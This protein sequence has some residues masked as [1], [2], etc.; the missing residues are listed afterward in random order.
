MSELRAVKITLTKKKS[1]PRSWSLNWLAALCL[2]AAVPCRA[3][4][5]LVPVDLQCKLFVKIF[6]FEPKL[7][8]KL[9]S[10]LVVGI[11]YQEKFRASLL[12]KKEAEQSFV[13]S[14]GK[15]KGRVRTIGIDLNRVEILEQTVADSGIHALYITPLRAVDLADITAISRQYKIPTLTGIVAYVEEGVSVAIELKDEKPQIVIN[16]PAAQAE[17]ANFS[18]KIL[19]LARVIK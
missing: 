5:M 12:A 3:Q 2:W 10:G 7:M 13:V 11:V 14:E 8:A 17:G 6:K 16:R 15:N 19:R 4:E 18:S 9:D 1:K